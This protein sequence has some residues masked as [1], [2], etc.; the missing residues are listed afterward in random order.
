MTKAKIPNWAEN[1]GK[2]AAQRVVVRGGAFMPPVRMLAG[3]KIFIATEEED[4]DER[5]QK[6]AHKVIAGHQHDFMETLVE[7]NYSWTIFLGDEVM[8]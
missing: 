5:Q 2:F 6:Y 3:G 4:K 1:D 8:N 7:V